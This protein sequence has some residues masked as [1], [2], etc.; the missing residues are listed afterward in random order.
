MKYNQVGFTL[1]E[2]LVVVLI[3][4]I[5]AAVALPQYQKAVT[6]SRLSTLKNTVETFTKAAEVYYLANN[7]YPTALDQL[8]VDLPPATTL[9]NIQATY[10]WGQC[11]LTNSQTDNMIVCEH[12]QANIVYLHRFAYSSS[13]PN[14]IACR[15]CDPISISVCQQDTQNQ[16]PYFEGNGCK[17][18]EYKN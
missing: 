18:Y 11:V 1:I 10:P 17:A 6:K 5:L 13:A 12:N 3:I 8:D 2:L 16:I 7:Q 4:G 9:T 15:G 14:Q